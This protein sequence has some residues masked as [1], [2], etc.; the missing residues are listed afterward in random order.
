MPPKPW[1]GTGR[2]PSLMRRRAP[3][4]REGAGAGTAAGH[5][6]CWHEVDANLS[7]ASAAVDCGPRPGHTLTQPRAEE[8]LLVEWPEGDAEPLKY[9]LSLLPPTSRSSGSH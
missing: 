1:R 3:R 4:L 2:P 9:W 5:R 7:F 8:W 6:V